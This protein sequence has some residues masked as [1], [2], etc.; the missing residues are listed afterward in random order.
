MSRALKPA[1]VLNVRARHTPAL[2]SVN[3][4][5]PSSNGQVAALGAAANK[6]DPELIAVMAPSRT[7]SLLRQVP[8]VHLQE[9]IDGRNA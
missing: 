4:W 5:L 1:S 6:D 7:L 8:L 9:N 3:N 2:A